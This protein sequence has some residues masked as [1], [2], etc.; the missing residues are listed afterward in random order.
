MRNIAACNDAEITV[1]SYFEHNVTPQERAEWDYKTAVGVAEAL[2]GSKQPIVPAIMVT[3]DGK[4]GT[5][6]MD[7][8]G[9]NMLMDLS[10]KLNK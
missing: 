10:K 4:S 5:N 9:M 6:P 7:V 3:G 8:V 2:A 1:A